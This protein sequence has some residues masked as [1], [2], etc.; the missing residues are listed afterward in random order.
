MDHFSRQTQLADCTGL[1]KESDRRG[2]SQ[3]VPKNCAKSFFMP[4]D[5]SPRE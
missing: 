3:K 1:G 2:T 4:P 5:Q